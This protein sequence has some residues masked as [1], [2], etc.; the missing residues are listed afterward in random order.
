LEFKK[1][2]TT[3]DSRS[4]RII[5]LDDES[6]GL[7][8]LNSLKGA[9]EEEISAGN[10]FIGLDLTEVNSINSSGLGILISCLKTIK[11]NN[12][13][14]KLLNASDKLFN[15]F[16]ITKLNNVFSITKTE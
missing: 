7:T 8:N 6:I 2:D 12:G 14:L 13:D 11:S 1:S 5:H 15:I 16:R 10:N 9:I 3:I 4:Y